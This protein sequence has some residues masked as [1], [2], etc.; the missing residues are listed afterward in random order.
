ME[1]CS[2]ARILS[3]RAKILVLLLVLA[4]GVSMKNGSQG[5][6]TFYDARREAET[7]IQGVLTIAQI[8]NLDAK[9]NL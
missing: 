3:A 6:Y 5:I 8:L 1:L 7:V 9:K 2:E 4:Q